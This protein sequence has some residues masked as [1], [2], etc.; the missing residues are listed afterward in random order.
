MK[1]LFV[2]AI[3]AFFSMT[4]FAQTNTAASEPSSV[5][6][7]KKELTPEQQEALQK[8]KSAAK[9]ARDRKK[10]LKAAKASGDQAAVDAAKVDLKAEKKKVKAEVKAAQATG[11]KAPM[12]KIAKQRKAKQE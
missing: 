11:V 4:S 10:A 7:T 3:V 2:V 8:V 12:K 6:L 5:Q 1:K 9:D